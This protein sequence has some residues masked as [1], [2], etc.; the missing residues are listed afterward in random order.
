MPPSKRG[1][2][3]VDPASAIRVP[4]NQKDPTRESARMSRTADFTGVGEYNT[5]PAGSYEVE[6]T[7]YEWKDPKDDGK[8]RDID[9]DTG[10]P[11]QYANMKWV[12]RDEVD[13]EGNKVEGH[14][15][16]NTYS[17]NPKSLFAMKRDAVAL[18]E[19]PE[20]FD[21]NTD[22]DVVLG[23]MSGRSG[24]AEVIYKEFAKEDG[25]VRKSNEIKKIE[26][27]EVATSISASRR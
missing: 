25:S 14:V 17:K 11:Y 12:V 24:I 18:G 3:R 23:N 4:K 8:K 10:K 13:A 16:F 26:P 2:K 6:A 15:L 7:S 9:P 1:R 22:L 19:D 5:I 27:L 20:F 21:E